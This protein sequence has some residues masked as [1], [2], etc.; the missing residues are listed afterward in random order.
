MH[1]DRTTGPSGTGRVH[2]GNPSGQSV[3][4]ASDGPDLGSIAA[5]GH[6]TLADRTS[7]SEY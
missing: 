3:R 1:P 5:Q 2:P 6:P 7:R 4:G